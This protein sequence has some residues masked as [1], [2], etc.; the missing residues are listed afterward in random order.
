MPR[1]VYAS[2]ILPGKL[3]YVRLVYKQKRESTGNE[4]EHDDFFKAIGLKGWRCWLQT[5]RNR[6]FFIHCLETPNFDYL[7][8]A[9]IEQIEMGHPK[10]VWIRDFYLESLGKDYTDITAKPILE[11]LFDMEIDTFDH[12]D[13]TIA[14]GY[15]YPLI[16][17]RASLHR[18]FNRQ[19]LGEYRVRV[20][21]ACYKQR[22]TRLTHWLQKTPMQDFIITYRERKRT[23]HPVD[24]LKLANENTS[25]KWFS[26]QLCDHSGLSLEEL[27]P[28]L[29]YLT[30]PIIEER[31]A[32]QY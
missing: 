18:E 12:S 16:P 24:T 15:I 19:L 6:P 8:D 29:E 4:T 7:F 28:K 26:E 21:D 22:I 25:Y 30:D 11:P 5:I 17:N 10:A 27:E 1:L 20:Q 2:A 14:E 23:N 9:L 31:L 3:E 32:L 13:P